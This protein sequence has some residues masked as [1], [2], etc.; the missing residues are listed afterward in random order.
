MNKQV[1]PRPHEWDSRVVVTGVVHDGFVN[2]YIAVGPFG[3]KDEKV[4]MSIGSF[5]RK[6]TDNEISCELCSCVNRAVM[7]FFDGEIEWDSVCVKER[8]RNELEKSF[9]GCLAPRSTNGTFICSDSFLTGPG[10]LSYE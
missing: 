5:V 4:I 7:P 8:I 6:M 3:N 1:M 2:V 9:R 10:T